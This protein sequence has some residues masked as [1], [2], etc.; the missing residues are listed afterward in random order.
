MIGLLLATAL[1]DHGPQPHPGLQQAT[2]A[3]HAAVADVRGLPFLRDVPVVIE[4]EAS[5]RARTARE[6]RRGRSRRDME[7]L[8]LVLEALRLGP[9]GLDLAQ[10][11]EDAFGESLG[12][13]YDPRLERLVL[14]T[15]PGE[16]EGNGF[17]P[18][19]TD[20]LVASHEL[21]HALQDQHGSID[22]LLE[23][24]WPSGDL[25][26][27]FRSALE[28][29][30][31]YAML[32]LAAGDRRDLLDALPADD[33]VSTYLPTPD[34]D[35]LAPALTRLPLAVRMALLAPYEQGVRFAHAVVQARG[36]AGLDAALVTPPLSTEHIL[37]PE[38][39]LE[40]DDPPRWPLLTSPTRLAG[41]GWRLLD[42]DALGELGTRALL[43][44]W[45]DRSPH[46]DVV[47]QAAA[48]WGGDRYA[49]L[50]HRA[51]GL[52]VQWWTA[53]DSAEDADQAAVALRAGLARADG[54]HALQVH[55][56]RVLLTLGLSPDT[57]QRVLAAL[58]QAEETRW[59]SLDDA[60]RTRH[61]GRE[62]TP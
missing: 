29:D 47:V 54:T 34:P 32:R 30:A 46:D 9:P 14:V 52:A 44:T 57:S 37:H 13:W 24:G 62:A 15:R 8:G 41:P 11:Q 35:D 1:A 31:T 12:G 43:A 40:L 60:R 22:A 51:H 48:G 58:A 33:F 39:W 19:S 25:S 59:T 20:G 4:D 38:R 23:G 42:D 16:F 36:I 2:D 5:V 26:L 45:L 55:G 3:L 21:V 50:S 18:T 7:R 27:A 17:A 10:L 53:W 56:D 6:N 28:G 61:P 49:V